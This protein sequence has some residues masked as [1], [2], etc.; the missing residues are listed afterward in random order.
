MQR[1]LEYYMGL[2]YNVIIEKVDSEKDPEN[3]QYLT[4]LIAELPGLK[5]EGKTHEELLIDLEIIKRF[6]FEFCIKHGKPIPEPGSDPSSTPL[7]TRMGWTV[8]RPIS[9]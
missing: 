7:D 5:A 6:Y 2:N 3:G 1:D 4:A 9:E 8:F